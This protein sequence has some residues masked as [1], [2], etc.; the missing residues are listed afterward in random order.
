MRPEGRPSLH[1]AWRTE[2][3]WAAGKGAAFLAGLATGFWK[4]AESLCALRSSDDV[5]EPGMEDERHAKL[6]EGWARAVKRT[7][8]DA[9][10]S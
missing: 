5:Y 10:S 3:R 6:L 7:M 2:G 4:D 9:L 8:S 1:V